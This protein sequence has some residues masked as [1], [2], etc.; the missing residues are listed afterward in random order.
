MR[1]KRLKGLFPY[2]MSLSLFKNEFYA[3]EHVTGRG[4]EKYLL[5]LVSYPIAT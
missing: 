1:R 5:N 3:V 2:P 4:F